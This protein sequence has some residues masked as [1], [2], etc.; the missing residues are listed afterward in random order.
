MLKVM[1]MD[2]YV[3]G[4]AFTEKLDYVLLV[5]KRRPDFQKGL[6][7]GIG[8][9]IDKGETPIDAMRRESLEEIG[10]SLTFKWD[11]KGVMKGIN[12]DGR[13]FECYIFYAYTDEINNYRQMEDEPLLFVNT[14][15]YKDLPLMEN[16]KFLI[17]MGMSRDHLSFA[18]FEY[19][20]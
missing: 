15:R 20:L 1:R 9:K 4:F 16:L 3:V 11:C 8:G 12:N 19:K 18:I 5:E 7:N 17:P 10:L 14:Q 6:I 2:R 13:L